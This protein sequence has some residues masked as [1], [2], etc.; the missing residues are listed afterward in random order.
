MRMRGFSFDVELLMMAQRRGYRIA[1]VPVNWH[2][3]PGSKVNLVTDSAKMV[4]DLFVIR[5]HYL[6]GEYNTPHVAPW[7]VSSVEPLQAS[8][9]LT[10]RHPE[11]PA[12][13]RSSAGRFS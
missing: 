3:V 1:E 13:R 10:H 4:R 9:R 11:G 5:G 6:R 12:G 8:H 2:H 7:S